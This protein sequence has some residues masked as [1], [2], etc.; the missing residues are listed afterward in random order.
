MAGGEV[1]GLVVRMVE[2]GV[3][4]G[5]AGEATVAGMVALTA[6]VAATPGTQVAVAS[7]ALVVAS[8]RPSDTEKR[9]ASW[10]LRGWPGRRQSTV[11]YHPN[12]PR[13]C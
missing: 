7:A 8:M 10:R 4:E 6:V 12:C 3:V 13:R 5:I 9:P 11:E 2:E 1:A